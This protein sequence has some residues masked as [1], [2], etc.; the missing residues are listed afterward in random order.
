MPGF[1]RLGDGRDG[2]GDVGDGGEPPGCLRLGG[3]DDAPGVLEHLLA[4]RGNAGSG[5]LDRRSKISCTS[6]VPKRRDPVSMISSRT[7]PTIS[8]PMA[9]SS[10]G[11]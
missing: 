9:W 11:E 6:V 8:R 2:A 5:S 3:G 7:C 1:L 10:S 4:A